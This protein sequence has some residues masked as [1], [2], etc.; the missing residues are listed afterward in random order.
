MSEKAWS[1]LEWY[2]SI[3]T[4]FKKQPQLRALFINA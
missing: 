3:G 4:A 2:A 1:L